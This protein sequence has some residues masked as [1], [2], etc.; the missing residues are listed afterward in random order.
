MVLTIGLITTPPDTT[1][2]QPLMTT[3]PTPERMAQI[4]AYR[5]AAGWALV[6]GR[7]AQAGSATIPPFILFVESE[8]SLN[9]SSQMGCY[10]LLGVCVRLM[11]KVGLHRDPSKLPDISPFEGEM[12]RRMWSLAVTIDTLVS[13]HVGLPSIVQGIESD[14][15]LPL[16]LVDEDFDESCAELPA[17]RA[18]TEYTGLS[19]PI[20]KCALARVF[21]KIAVYSHA[22]TP[23]SYTE[24]QRLD[25][26]LLDT[27]NTVP[28]TMKPRPLEECITDHPH[29][30]MQRSGLSSLFHKSRCVLHRRYLTEPVL[31]AEH[32]AS[33]R[34]CLESALEL[35]RRHDDL[36][37]DPRPGHIFGSGV[38]FFS[39]LT[40][41]D[42]LLAST[43]VYICVQSPTYPDGEDGH[44]WFPPGTV[45]PSKAEL[46]GLLKSH[47]YWVAL[48]EGRADF[49]KVSTVIGTMLRK[50]A[51]M[52]SDADG[53]PEGVGQAA[54]PAI[55]EPPQG[56]SANSA[57]EMSTL[58]TL[59]SLTH[60]PF[61]GGSRS[62]GHRSTNISRQ[63]TEATALP[64]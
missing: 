19:Y 62:V 47:G 12:R 18:M 28:W 10:V 1:S 64:S 52:L 49:E 5:A 61:P 37:R 15:A 24:V 16:N 17:P 7:Y 63:L 39:V 9:T 57:T 54:Q 60:L 3:T 43:V 36:W 31:R 51:V 35:L 40:V 48:I 58:G 20:N 4:K 59:I 27:W 42:F 13:F 25:R 50:L 8:M 33:R 23:P 53:S 34:T 46:V 6:Y 55:S 21:G 30:I 41:Y 29:Q 11:L 26:L 38:W 44:P 22:L 14:T 32:A 45:V 2:G 56:V